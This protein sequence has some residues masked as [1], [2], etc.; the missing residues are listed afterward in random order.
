MTFSS[1]TVGYEITEYILGAWHISRVH[2]VFLR[3]RICILQSINYDY[4]DNNN[5]TYYLSPD[6]RRVKLI[7]RN[8]TL[9]VFSPIKIFK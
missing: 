1:L 3:E 2:L 7:V 8:R 9:V 5:H 4:Y 6:Q